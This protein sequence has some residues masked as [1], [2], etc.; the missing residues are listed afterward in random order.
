MIFF[1]LH[2]LDLNEMQQ[3]KLWHATEI[4]NYKIQRLQR[5]SYVWVLSRLKLTFL[6]KYQF[7]L[8]FHP[9]Q[10]FSV[11]WSKK[12]KKPIGFQKTLMINQLKLIF[13]MK[14]WFQSWKGSNIWTLFYSLYPKCSTYVGLNLV[15]RF[16]FN[17]QKKWLS[18]QMKAR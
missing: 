12:K 18:S 3:V 13:P 10:I 16:S 7:E 5:C 2:I 6:C 15:Y 1:V 8:I 11:I 9:K 14:C 4:T 17:L